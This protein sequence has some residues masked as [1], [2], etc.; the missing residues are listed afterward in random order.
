MKEF[1]RLSKYI[2]YGTIAVSDFSY[3]LVGSELAVTDQK[4]T[5]D[6]QVDKNVSTVYM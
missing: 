2:F 1:F 3:S 6:G 4:E 5:Y